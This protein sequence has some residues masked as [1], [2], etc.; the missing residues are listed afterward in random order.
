[1]SYDA[2]REQLARRRE[3]GDF[4]K[5]EELLFDAI[6]Q[7]TTVLES[8]LTQIKVALGHVA[9]LLEARRD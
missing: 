7:L 4:T 2:I 8:D 3:Q 5:N 9:R 1:M 6:H